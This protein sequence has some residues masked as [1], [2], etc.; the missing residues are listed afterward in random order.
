[1]KDGYALHFVKNETDELCKL[2]DI[3]DGGALEFVKN[4]TDEIC[5]WV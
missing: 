2:A 3:N 5:K 1:M 4:E